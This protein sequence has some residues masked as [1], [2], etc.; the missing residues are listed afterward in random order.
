MPTPFQLRA[1][2]HENSFYHLVCKSIDGILLFNDPKDFTVFSKKFHH[3]THIFLDNWSYT[4]LH[5]HSHHILKFRSEKDVAEKLS[6]LPLEKLTVSSRMFL[7]NPND[8]TLF[9]K[10]IERQM[11]SFL[12]SYSH[13]YNRKY[14][15]KGG[16]F[17]KPFKRIAI[18][19]EAHLQHAIIYTHAN[20]QKHGLIEHFAYYEHSSYLKILN[21]DNSQ[22]A[23]ENVLAFFGGIERFEMLH[24]KQA[25]YYYMRW[26]LLRIE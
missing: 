21:G 17:Q 16:L 5:N 10:M 9:N 6:K 15:R 23:A 24:N 26:P 12:V 20:S 1:T 14:Q 4:L 2:F 18:T 8:E 22:V 3:Y 25:E 13:Y 7:N 19:D 11:N